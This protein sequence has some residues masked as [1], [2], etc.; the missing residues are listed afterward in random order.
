M[1]SDLKVMVDGS[2]QLSGTSMDSSPKLLLSKGGEKAFYEV[3]PGRSCGSEVHVVARMG[4]QPATNY[5]CLVG[6][7]VV[8]HNMNVQMRGSGSV[9][10]VEEFPKLDGTVSALTSPQN[11][12][13][14]HV[15]GSKEGCRAMPRVVMGA[16]LHLSR[17]HGQQGL[18]AVKS[19]NLGLFVY[20]QDQSLVGRVHVQP[21]N[22]PHL[23]NEER[24]VDSLKVSVRCGWRAN[25]RQIRLMALWL[26]PT[27]RA[28]DRVLQ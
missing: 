26:K 21:H 14:L 18:R 23:L 3:K 2:F 27:L 7:V 8:H 28:N 20:T 22:V 19:L 5:R 10:L 17:T 6:S 9:D 13:S 25:A 15:K 24:S 4:C 1:V 12:A 11:L 16:A